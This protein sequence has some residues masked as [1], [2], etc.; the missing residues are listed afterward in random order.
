M[1]GR[2]RGFLVLL[3]ALLVAFW[4][5]GGTRPLDNTD[6][7]RDAQITREML[8][9]GD[10][11]LPHLNGKPL[12]WK[13]MLYHWVS[14]IASI[15]A[16]HVSE[17]TAALPSILAAILCALLTFDMAKRLFGSRRAGLVAAA[18]LLT[19]SQ[20]LVKSV[21]A[22]Y[23]MTLTGFTTLAI[24]AFWRSTCARS[25]GTSLGFSLL[26]YAAMGLGTITKGPVGILV[27][28]IVAVG[29]LW[30]RRDWF[31]IFRTS[32][33]F[34]VPLLLA[35]AV[36]WYWATYV[37]GGKEFFDEIFWHQNFTRFTNAFDHAAG[38]H[39]Y[40]IQFTGGS[41][42]W[43]PLA[44]AAIPFLFL[45]TR[46]KWRIR[47]RSRALFP[48]AWFVIVFAFFTASTSKRP[49]YI[50]PLYPAAALLAAGFVEAVLRSR[51]SDLR[52]VLRR[53]VT[54][55]G[56][57]LLVAFPAPVVAAFVQDRE[58]TIGE[59]LAVGLPGTLALIA[60]GVAVVAFARRDRLGRAVA[61][62][63]LASAALHVVG[64]F[65]LIASPDGPFH[66]RAFAERARH[67]VGAVATIGFF[68]TFSP[69]ILYYLGE[70]I[71]VDDFQGANATDQLVSKL[72]QR[73]QPIHLILKKKNEATDWPDRDRVQLTP[74]F[75]RRVGSHEL[76]L[77]RA[78]L[79]R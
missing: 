30:L 79:A 33:W 68:N 43:S 60:S 6:E 7:G 24:W 26:F 42:P 23:D 10:W 59:A 48:L 56:V 12:P 14:G 34:G 41:L 17:L 38:P 37:R 3:A 20:F 19:S 50:L 52:V 45:R 31:G 40:F 29:Y 55:I 28:G 67:E 78:T 35:V 74:L 76:T 36:P 51:H 18:A 64:L 72:V 44:I 27:P 62:I 8:D 63:A 21:S 77:G 22:Q 47:R 13:P 46:G 69:G 58:R 1:T 73:G 57:A 70:P 71:P 66:A 65:T 32:P 49:N 53:L 5:Y 15:P 11:V 16:G 54:A 39:Y 75:T 9:S 25:S 61:S 2:S 4:I